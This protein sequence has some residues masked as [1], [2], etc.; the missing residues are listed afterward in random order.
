MILASVVAL[1]S[2]TGIAILVV[3]EVAPAASVTG[4]PLVI[5]AGRPS[6]VGFP[7]TSVLVLLFHLSSF[8]SR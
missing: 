1:A 4:S 2:V 7:A 8:C 3:G 5:G 6:V